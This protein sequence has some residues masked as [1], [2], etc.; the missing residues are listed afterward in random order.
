MTLL[1]AVML[2]CGAAL[3]S[4]QQYGAVT[5]LVT[6]G[7]TGGPLS[8]VQI[9]VA[10]TN[11]GGLTNADG[12]FLLPRV[13]LGQQTIRA[14]RIGYAQQSQTVT[15]TAGGTVSVNFTLEGSAVAVEGLVV[16]A[17]G[18]QQRTREVGVAVGKVNM[19]NVS[20]AANANISNTLQSRVPGVTVT[21]AGGTTG[22]GSRIRIRG[23]A[24]ISLNNSPLIVIDGVRASNSTGNSIGV[25]GQDVSRLD[26]I[27]A[28]DIEKIEVLKGP[29]AS[30]MYG[31]AA[32]N[33][34][35][36]ITTKK[37][38]AG[39]T[40]WRGYVE[41]GSLVE[42]NDYPANYLGYCSYTTSS[43]HD[44]S[45]CDNPYFLYLQ[46]AGVSPQRDSVQ[47]Y[48]PLMAKGEGP[49]PFQTGAREK[50]GLSAQGGSERVTYFL[51]GDFAHEKGVYK[52]VSN[53][54]DLNLRANLSAQLTDKLDASVKV[55]W[56]D[57][58]LR[59]PQNDNNVLGILPSAYLG[60]ATPE[61]AYGFFTLPDLQA[62][63]TEQ[64]VRRVIG[65]AQGN[66]NLLP[67]LSFNGTIG[68][69]L[70]QRH[71][72]ETIPPQRVFYGSLPEG[73][74]TSNRF[75]LGT[76]TAQLNGSADFELAS[77]I[78]ARTN[79][80]VQY[81]DTKTASTEAYGRGLL[82]GCFSL[83]CVATG[84]DVDETHTEVKT[85]GVY[86]SQQFS[87]ND[88]LYITGTVRGDDNSAFG[89]NLQ[90]TYYPSVNL[91]W[92]M[93]EEP[94]F[95]AISGLSLFRVRAGYGVSGLQPGFR[96][97]SRYLN[98]ASTIIQG[99][100]VPAFN[101]G[102]IGNPD[103]K[104]E[105]SKELE[106]GA[107]IGLFQDRMALELTYYNKKSNDALVNRDLPPSLGQPTT[108]TVNLGEMQNKGVEV[109]VRGTLMNTRDVLWDASV[110]YS[111]N[112]NTLTSLGTDPNT[113]EPIQPIIF[114]LGGD[115][116]RFQ[117]GF[118]AGA[119]FARSYT[120]DDANGDGFLSEDEVTLADTAS[121]QGAPIPANEAS[122]HT[123][124]TL[125]NKVSI[126]ALMD[127]K[128]GYKM[129]NATEEFRCA[130]FFNCDATYAGYPGV[131]VSLEDQA[132]FVADAYGP[133][134]GTVAG[135]FQDGT[136]WKLREV[137]ASFSLPD[138]WAGYVQ[139]RDIRVTLAGRNLWMST[140]YGGPDPEI[141]GGGS[142]S[143][144]NT[145]DFLSQP[146]IRYYTVRL[147]LT[148]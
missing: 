45:Y 21:Q 142:G 100:V 101:F 63:D 24:S 118:P 22:T 84:F 78:G 43:K 39:S 34:V 19:D 81:V 18:E 74:R 62:I 104:P 41:Q 27:A 79:V 93:G 103:L 17:T 123:S 108:Q 143:N 114:G 6:D 11:I 146:Q 139:A 47:V 96:T 13:P 15:V 38:T 83:N 126:S 91:S 138:E 106:L 28:E 55:G 127:Y 121:Y 59:L 77:N 148:F 64:K 51:S 14:I 7:A 144:F 97:A 36:V 90:F 112:E 33:G 49:Y 141:N 128:G 70:I 54:K 119:Y 113:G 12:R 137:T 109:L 86:L 67:W 66:L 132:A 23:S 85:L 125:F 32:A 124:V 75:E 107:D 88:R 116:Q 117:E 82:A 1:S 102:G 8:A 136:F 44:V 30:A 98:P 57:S 120:Y 48:N 147:D 99:S 76:Y 73:E 20:L 129:Y 35:I 5:G 16:T 72:N 131:N 95:P 42:P 29:A 10:N 3:A 80:G 145:F 134:G 130:Q 26:D 58:N 2:L 53:L 56:V 111:H 69:D 46:D 37:G 135:Y 105:I 65:S 122:F 9:Q 87:F 4:A 40:R 133:Q 31:T 50:Y 92:V 60:G 89:K 110:S 61:T 140:K 25:G 68:M 94:W 71:D 52:K 115:S